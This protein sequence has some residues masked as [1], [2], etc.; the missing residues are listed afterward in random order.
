MKAYGERFTVYISKKVFK[1]LEHYAEV[2]QLPIGRLAAIAVER[3]LTKDKPFDVEIKLPEKG[4]YEEFSYS[5]EAGKIMRWWKQNDAMVTLD[6]A[7]ILR[8]DMGIEE[9]EAFLAGMREC[10][11]GGFL[12]GYIPRACKL[13]EK[14]FARNKNYMKIRLTNKS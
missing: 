6:Q 13:N 9:G 2:L 11:E 7:Y 14:T 8:H 12:E 4:T 10:M 5:D 3:E 1:Y